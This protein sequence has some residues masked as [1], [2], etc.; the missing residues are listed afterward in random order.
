[1]YDLSVLYGLYN[2]WGVST[3]ACK[4]ASICDDVHMHTYSMS[5]TIKI[6]KTHSHHTHT[7]TTYIHIHSQVHLEKHSKG[8]W[9]FRIAQQWLQTRWTPLQQTRCTPLQQTRCTPLQPNLGWMP[10]LCRHLP[11]SMPPPTRG[12]GPMCSPRVQ[13]ST[14]MELVT[15]LVWLEEATVTQ[16]QV[17]LWALW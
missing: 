17:H 1:M 2:V 14:S 11:G 6:H 13:C 9:C 16:L 7:H 3:P 8:L 5:Y 4:C 10:V 12:M 15:G